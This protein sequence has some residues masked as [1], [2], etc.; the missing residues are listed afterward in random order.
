[1]VTHL[2]DFCGENN[3]TRFCGKFGEGKHQTGNASLCIVSK[4]LFLSVF[5][6]DIQLDGKQLMNAYQTKV[7]LSNGTWFELRISEGAT[8]K[9]LDSE[10]WCKRHF[11]V[12]R[13]GMTCEEM[14]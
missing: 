2:L 7:W 14:R 1:M 4:A 6:D 5:V 13:H 10:K 11:V 12:L 3:L 8:E 9:F